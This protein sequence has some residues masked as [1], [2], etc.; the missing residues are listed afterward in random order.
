MK[1]T[2]I[3]AFVVLAALAGAAY[4]ASCPID[5]SS[6]YFTGTTKFDSASGKMLK[7]Y[8]CSRGHEFWSVN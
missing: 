1:K 4:A 8:R 7:L 3:L 2:K 6:A 5:D